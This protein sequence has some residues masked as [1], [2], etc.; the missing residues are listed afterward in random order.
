VPNDIDYSFGKGKIS[1]YAKNDTIDMA[2][3]FMDIIIGG[4]SNDNVADNAG[5]KIELFM[6]DTLF[7][8][9]GITDANPDL[10]AIIDDPGGINT[11][12]SG[13]GHDIV[14]YIDGER[15]NSFVLNNYFENDFNSYRKGK[16]IYNIGTLAA[17]NHSLTLKA[18]DNFN[19]SSEETLLFSVEEGG[20][21]VLKN[22][23]NYP[24][25][26]TN[27]TKISAE[28]NRPGKELDVTISIFSLNGK[29]IRT[30]RQKVSPE[31]YRLPPLTWD[32]NADGGKR[33]GRGIYYYRVTVTTA[34]GERASSAGKL[35]IL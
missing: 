11:T 26:V 19:N 15:N 12:G 13:I 7:R 3:S 5:P 17:G 14:A 2:G 35:I 33:A 16:I 34:G 10:L 29:I 18:W 25:P 4:F 23:I 27:G 24:N 21:F 6:N 31:G 28:H 30:I 9:G 20:V 8:K 22:L 32:G 1:Y